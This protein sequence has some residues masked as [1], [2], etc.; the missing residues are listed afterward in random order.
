MSET[1]SRLTDADQTLVL[2]ASAVINLLGTSQIEGVLKSL[3]RTCVVEANA[4]REVKRDPLTGASA[5]GSLGACLENRVL[6]K[7]QMTVAATAVFLDLVLAQPPDGLDD[8]EAASVAHAIDI[9]ASAVIDERKATRICAAAFPTL[10]VLSTLDIL[11]HP[12]VL[13]ELGREALSAAVFSALQHARMRVQPIFVPWVVQL[14]GPE[15]V[16]QS[17]SLRRS[18]S[19][20]SLRQA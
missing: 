6:I 7:H 20:E 2:D 11:S 8:G 17:P 13:Q 12:R 3:G 16:A 15:R 4:W 18:R 9:G 5:D 10:K 1:S 19:P 14:L